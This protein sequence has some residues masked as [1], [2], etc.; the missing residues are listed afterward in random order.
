MGGYCNSIRIVEPEKLKELLYDTIVITSMPGLESIKAQVISMGIDESR[1]DDS[2]VIGPLESRRIFLENF[3]SFDF[4][5][6][7]SVAEAGVFEGDFA[8]WINVYFPDH[9]LHLF[10][11]FEGFDERD[12][13][14]EEGLSSV[15]VGDY[16][17]TSQN[18]VM[19]KMIHP[20]KV[21]I[22]CGYF[23]DTATGID[24]VFCFVNLDMDLYEPT[25]RGLELFSGKMV[26]NGAILVH[27]YFSADF[28]GPKKAVDEFVMNHEDY[29]IYPI[30]DGIS[31]LITGFKEIC[32]V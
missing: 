24:D 28:L 17:N 26:K 22:H 31:I 21:K 7:V 29:S 15:K 27:D 8:K 32:G 16:N 9:A 2:F 18:V 13:L 30:G 1:I 3:A 10:D 20:E 23:P 6:T 25:Y 12:I 5:S 4:P 14:K 19:K 11:T